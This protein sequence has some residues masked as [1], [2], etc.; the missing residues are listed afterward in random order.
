MF[1]L[2]CFFILN[3]MR[4]M[5]VMIG[6]LIQ[7]PQQPEFLVQLIP[8]QTDVLHVC[9]RPASIRVDKIEQSAAQHFQHHLI[10]AIFIANFHHY[11]MPAN[12]HW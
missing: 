9:W 5:D 2:A 8:A 3:G 4:E 6:R 1:D 10:H 11:L 7:G 12:G